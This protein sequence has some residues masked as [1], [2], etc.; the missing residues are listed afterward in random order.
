MMPPRM[1][2]CYVD[3]YKYF[4]YENELP[5]VWLVHG[6]LHGRKGTDLE[7]WVYGHAWIE[8]GDVVLQPVKQASDGKTYGLAFVSRKESFYKDY[9]VR[10]ETLR[11]YPNKDIVMKLSLKTGQFGPW[12]DLGLGERGYINTNI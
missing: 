3:V 9:L 10:M 2:T 12:H 4:C 6:V 1:G 7:G 11:R 5:E 8:M